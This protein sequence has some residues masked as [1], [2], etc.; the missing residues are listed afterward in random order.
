MNRPARLSSFG[1]LHDSFTRGMV[2]RVRVGWP[3]CGRPSSIAG[4]VPSLCRALKKP[5]ARAAFLMDYEAVP[6]AGGRGEPGIPFPRGNGTDHADG[7]SHGY[8]PERSCGGKV[9]AKTG[10]W[11]KKRPPARSG[12]ELS[13]GGKPAAGPSKPGGGAAYR[14]CTGTPAAVVGWTCFSSIPLS[15]RA[16]TNCSISRPMAVTCAAENRSGS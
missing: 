4:E 1:L 9:M 6:R 8:Q 7:P 14:G 12:P 13:A 3:R 2:C 5:P 10:A 16:W 15:S 11:W